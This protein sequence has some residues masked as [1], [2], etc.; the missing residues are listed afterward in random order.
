MPNAPVAMFGLVLL[1]LPAL[2]LAD[3]PVGDSQLLTGSYAG[4]MF[5]F[6]ASTSGDVNGDGYSDLLV[7]SPNYGGSVANGGRVQL[8]LGTANGVSATPVWTVEGSRAQSRFG[9]SVSAAGDVNGDGFDDVVIGAPGQ[10]INSSDDGRVFIYHGSPAGPS[11]SSD[12]NLSTGW[13]GARFGESVSTAGD[14]NGDGYDDIVIGAPKVG[15]GLLYDEQGSVYVY[16]GSSSGI[17]STFT[18]SVLGPPQAFNGFG[19]SVATAG[20]LNGDGY[21]DLVVGAE[22]YDTNPLFLDHGRVQVYYGSGT[23][24]GLN[25]NWSLSG[26]AY[27][28]QFGA[29]VSTAG[30]VN[31]DG[32]ADLLVGAPRWL[33]GPDEAGLVSLYLGSSTGPITPAAWTEEGNGEELLGLSV[34]TAGDVDADGYADILVGA[35]FYQGGGWGR[36]RAALYR[37]GPTGPS[38]FFDWGVNYPL[39]NSVYGLSV[40]SAGDLNGDG[41]GDIVIGIPQYDTG[42]AEDNTGRIEVLYGQKRN[43]TTASAWTG[44]G[45]EVEAYFGAAM[46]SAGDVNGDGFDDIIIGAYGAD[47][48][49]TDN[50]RVDVFHGSPDGP[51]VYSSPSWSMPGGT[52]GEGFGGAVAGVGDVDG[53]GYDDVLIGSIYY[54]GTVPNEGKVELYLGSQTGLGSTPAWQRALGQEGGYLWRVAKAGDINGDGFSDILM[55]ATGWDGTF[56]DEGKVWLY[57]GSATGPGTEPAWSFEGGALVAFLGQIG[58]AGDVNA[59]GYD[60]VLVGVGNYTNNFLGEGIARCFYGSASGLSTT[61]DWF[62]EGAEVG[63]HL[64]EVSTAGDVNGDGYADV[65]V[66]AWYGTAPQAGSG[67]AKI[68]HGSAGGL[69]PLPAVTLGQVS[70]GTRFGAAV[71]GAGDVN[72]DG[73]SDVIVGAP[74]F[75]GVVP[76]GGAAYLYLGS[77]T[78]IDLTGPWS[79]YSFQTGSNFGRYVR[80]LGDVDGDGLS[81]LAVSATLMDNPD[82][83]EGM[84]SVYRGGGGQFADN[85]SWPLPRQLRT[86]ATPLARGGRSDDMAA[87]KLEA[88]GRSAAG[89]TRVRMEWMVETIGPNTLPIVGTLGTW[90]DSGAVLPAD[91]SAITLQQTVGGLLADTEYR[92]R[93]RVRS[94]SPYFPWTRWMSAAGNVA[95]LASFRTALD[96]ATGVSGDRAVAAAQ[97]RLESIYPNPFNPRTEIIF[98]LAAAGRIEVK[99]F[100]QRGRLVR[101]V[102]TK[103]LAPGIHAV[104]WDGTDDAGCSV[105]S[106][107]YFA[108]IESETGS[109][110]G[111]MVLVR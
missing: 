78:G 71:D 88:V 76:D 105:A 93:L 53:D 102:L 98:S 91:G 90:Y 85:S 21:A 95:T 9:W 11:T 34:T 73:F 109:A 59:D 37:G 1:L 38:L 27:H 22:T 92:W 40:G 46:R 66:G 79:T 86:G 14:L 8:F 10:P 24:I 94:A 101:S 61:P 17:A 56:D 45:D 60:D 32:Y 28:S 31:G 30:D 58:T 74:D 2:S 99:V 75:G 44:Q 3:L 18:T 110:R 108:R 87:M 82:A 100:D 107:V 26:P 52:A 84:V 55:A 13:L 81:D 96:P 48:G 103:Q 15:G 64:I 111:R 83:D 47:A 72:G 50:G 68:Y 41:H 70:S 57:L 23:G 80:G 42:S 106:A 33:V 35:P 29:S 62:V 39:D 6:S 20:D 69:E 25:P 5:G 65:I 54:S 7:G 51:S 4:A 36:G 104:E 49:L 63:A 89:R 97:V 77:P 43:P 12:Q 16:H 67:W 19:N